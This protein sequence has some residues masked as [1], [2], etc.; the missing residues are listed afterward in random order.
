VHQTASRLTA[1]SPLMS[2]LLLPLLLAAC[3]TTTTPQTLSETP[4]A[5]SSLES[6]QA[7]VS[8]ATHS[9]VI[10]VACDAVSDDLA[11][12]RSKL[13]SKS[14]VALSGTCR[15]G[16]TISLAG[17]KTLEGG[18][19]VA[20][21]KLSAIISA[22][23][24]G[25]TVRN[26]V[27]DGVGSSV[28]IQ[29]NGYPITVSSV[30]AMN[31][32]SFGVLV[33]GGTG[34]R[35][36]GF[37]GHRISGHIGASAV[38]VHKAPKTIVENIT[39]YDIMPPDPANPLT[40]PPDG[41]GVYIGIGSDG[42]TVTNVTGTNIGRRLL[43]IQS[44]YVTARGVH[45]TGVGHS[46]VQVELDQSSGGPIRGCRLFDINHTATKNGQY[47]M[48]FDAAVDDCVVDGFNFVGMFDTGIDIRESITNVTIK[49]GTVKGSARWGARLENSG[50]T[51]TSKITFDNVTFDSC[52]RNMG[53][54]LAVRKNSTYGTVNYVTVNAS[55]FVN[56]RYA[57]E[58]YGVG[59]T[60]TNNNFGAG[61]V[62][63][64]GTGTVAFNNTNYTG[65]L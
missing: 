44:N 51:G 32:T 17:G 59:H 39:A 3:G 13:A 26:T 62:S 29:N 37:K 64:S 57:L 34:S 49:N 1:K 18:R 15:V 54:A 16:G 6:P 63:V 20:T 52:Y 8:P 27:I 9:S 4:T 47:G 35:I 31:L 50:G 46:A 12:I 24:A 7:P 45:A 38:L 53:P 25:A 5:D 56:N 33:R 48:M 55:R 40:Q 58:A 60:F 22:T 11:A 28:A 2:A 23:G 30:E 61:S 65:P 19:I 43:K 36:S 42:T 14:I 10:D 41:N 21:T